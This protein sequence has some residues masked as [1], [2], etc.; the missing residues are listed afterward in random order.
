VEDGLLDSTDAVDATLRLLR[1]APEITAIFACN[2]TV[3]MGVISAARKLG[4]AVPERLSVVGF[5]DIDLAQEMKPTLTTVHVD[6]VL[7]GVLAVRMLRDH[8]AS[9]ERP[10]LTTLLST[11]LIVRESTQSW[12][13]RTTE[14]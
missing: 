3:A 9:P 6:K 5:D 13:G 7:L 11:Q 14:P 1:R 10:A 4:L 2:D 8:A 12:M